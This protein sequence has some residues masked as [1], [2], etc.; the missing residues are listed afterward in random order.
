MK[1]LIL[2]LS[3][4]G[5]VG[6]LP[7]QE[8]IQ[9]TRDAFNSGR[10]GLFD[11]NSSAA[12]LYGIAE[13]SG[14][15]EGDIYLDT[16]FRQANIIF[17]QEVVRRYDP[18]ASDSIG[19]Y[20]VRIDLRNFVVEFK[21]GEIVKG[22]EPTAIRRIYLNQGEP[23]RYWNVG[24]FSGRPE[25]LEGFVKILAAGPLTIVKGYA[26]DFIKPTYHAALAVGEKNA[27]YVRKEAY[28][29]ARGQGNLVKFKPKRKELLGLMADKVEALSAYLASSNNT[30]AT[31]QEVAALVAYYN[32]LRQ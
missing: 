5:S 21:L 23:E 11:P 7:G 10:I 6:L 3:C 29:Y 18:K 26:L 27:R 9:S 14:I 19:G 28:Y 30:L 20:P 2:L 31:E 12:T 25:G 17:Y 4:L 1:K 16:A 8:M 32:S 13:G 15:V 24:E 22:I